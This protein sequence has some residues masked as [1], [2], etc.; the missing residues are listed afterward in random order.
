MRKINWA[1]FMLPVFCFTGCA[2]MYN[3]DATYTFNDRV[4]VT[5]D[6]NKVRLGS[7]GDELVFAFN[8]PPGFIWTVNIKNRW[9]EPIRS[10][11]ITLNG[12]R[13]SDGLFRQIK[14]SWYWYTKPEDKEKAKQAL[15]KRL[16]SEFDGNKKSYYQPSERELKERWN[17]AGYE[18]ILWFKSK[19]LG[20]NKRYLCS[21]SLD[22]IGGINRTE[23]GISNASYDIF[24]INFYCTFNYTDGRMGSLSIETTFTVNHKD[25]AAD[26]DRVDKN[27]ALVEEFLKPI[28]DSLEVNPKAYQ[29]EAPK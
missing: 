9:G 2:W 25:L 23:E 1:L 22:R 19:R 5:A 7:K 21:E 28:F 18:Q 4:V 6:P 20:E 12:H 8:P 29:Y 15:Q 10:G 17:Q 24:P 27:V 16:M 26:P 11:Y 14:A 3:K 13:E